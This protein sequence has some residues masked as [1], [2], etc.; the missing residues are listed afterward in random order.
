VDF[1]GSID[2]WHV[3]NSLA[4]IAYI[5]IKELILD[6]KN[7]SKQ[8]SEAQSRKDPLKALELDLG[9]ISQKVINLEDAITDQ[10]EALSNKLDII[11][12]DFKDKHT[13][14]R[15]DL[16]DMRKIFTEAHRTLS[17]RLAAVEVELRLKPNRRK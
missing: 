7:L 11:L 2:V 6:R 10:G 4:L 3:L 14:N 12:Q 15:N 17:E 16:N 9:K 5:L 1:F 8:L 13:E